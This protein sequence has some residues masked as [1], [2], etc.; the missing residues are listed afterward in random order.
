MVAL[1]AQ[2]TTKNAGK[3]SELQPF[4]NTWAVFRQHNVNSDACYTLQTTTTTLWSF[5]RK[6]RIT[7]HVWS[8]D[9]EPEG[10]TEQGI[11]N[12]NHF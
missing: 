6:S 1:R 10:K 5:P 9:S 11:Y 3:W 8:S 7:S 12:R 2:Y 4:D